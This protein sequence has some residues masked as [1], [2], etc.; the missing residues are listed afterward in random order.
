[1]K[2]DDYSKYLNTVK[3]YYDKEESVTDMYA[4]LMDWSDGLILK[5]NLVK[6]NSYSAKLIYNWLSKKNMGLLGYEHLYKT[7]THL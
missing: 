1:M 5:S 7:L 2:S 4:D 6:F 3:P